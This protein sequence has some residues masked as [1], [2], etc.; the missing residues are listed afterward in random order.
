LLAKPPGWGVDDVAS[1]REEVA[2]CSRDAMWAIR[3]GGD[4]EHVLGH[5]D[6]LPESSVAAL[7][8]LRRQ[9][10]WRRGRGDR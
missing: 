7:E 2:E 8:R 5:Q 1:V 3:A 10:G 9:S 4:A 6:P